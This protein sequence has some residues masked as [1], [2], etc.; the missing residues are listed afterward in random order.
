MVK[1]VLENFPGSNIHEVHIQNLQLET[2]DN[3]K[4]LISQEEEWDPFEENE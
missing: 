2:S 1:S 3:D 4:I